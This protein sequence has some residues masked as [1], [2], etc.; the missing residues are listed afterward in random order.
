MFMINDNENKAENEKYIT[1]I[2]RNDL[3]PDIDTNILNVKCVSENDGIKQRLSN[4]WN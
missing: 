4:I 1:M 2:W 3:C